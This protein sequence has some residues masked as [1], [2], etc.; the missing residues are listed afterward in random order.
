MKLLLEAK[1]FEDLLDEDKEIVNEHICEWIKDT[2]N[3]TINEIEVVSVT[4]LKEE[5]DGP[6]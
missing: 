4:K 3:E 1:V 5:D 2:C 6:T